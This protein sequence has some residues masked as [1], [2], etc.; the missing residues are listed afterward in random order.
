ML[1]LD[2][3][4]TLPSGQ[5]VTATGTFT[6]STVSSLLNVTGNA[7]LGSDASDTVTFNALVDSNIIPNADNSKDLGSSSNR[8]RHIYA[9]DITITDDFN[10]GDDLNVTGALDV[11]GGA[12][13]NTLTV[14]GATS[15]VGAVDIDGAITRDGGTVLFDTD[16]VLKSSIN[17]YRCDSF[18]KI[19]K[20]SYRSYSRYS[21]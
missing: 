15:L 20:H 9:H 3:D 11:D 21:V 12:T 6:N 2:G 8:W 4:V 1:L 14:T 18:R 5:T 7:D 10:I 13:V 17:C 16:G 19:S